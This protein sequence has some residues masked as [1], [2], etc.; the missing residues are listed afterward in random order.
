[1]KK[2]IPIADLLKADGYHTGYTGKGV[3]PFQYARDE[4]DSLWRKENAAGKSYHSIKYK[5]NDPS[6]DRPANLIKEVNY[7]ANFRDFMEEREPGQPFY[8][9]YGGDEPHRGYEKDSWKRHGKKLETVDVPEF[10]PESK[11]VKGDMLDYA[12]EIEWFDKHL[13]RMLDYLDSTGELENT[14]VLVTSDNGMPFP[15][16][17]AN[18]YEYGIHVPLAVRCPKGFPGKRIVDDPVSFVDFAPTI[19]EMTGTE[20]DGMMPISG[21]SLVNILESKKSGVVD[22]QK[23]YIYAGRERVVS[24]RWKNLGY[25]QRAIRSRQYL[26]IWNLRPERWPAGAPRQ[27]NPESGEVLPLYDLDESGKHRKG[28]G[29]FADVDPSPSKSYVIEHH[30]DKNIRPYFDLIFGKRPDYELYEVLEDPYCINNLYEKQEYAQ[31]R[32]ELKTELMNELKRSGDPRVVG[33]DTEI[34]DSYKRYFTMREY[35]EP[36]WSE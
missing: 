10:L 17:K 16:A 4:K 18:C 21:K 25:P 6:D 8:F 34:F 2:H 36:C 11:A 19:L 5:R 22:E 27:V 12:V 1:M 28:Q 7:F 23:E 26:L 24:S 15:R 30:G 29:A 33:P 20:P 9:W 13:G 14:I 35:P 3:G 31:I 32:D